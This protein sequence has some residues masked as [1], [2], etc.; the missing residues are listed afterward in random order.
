MSFEFA[1]AGRVLFGVGAL[2]QAGA[3][4]RSFGSRALLITGRSAQRAAA[5]EASLSASN[6]TCSRFALDG[7]PSVDEVMAATAVAR[8]Q[9]CEVIL[10]FGGGSAMDAAK[11]VAALLSNPGDPM[12]YLEVVGR[13]LPLV[14]VSIPCIAIPTTSGTGAEVTRN[15]VLA[16]PEH[17]VKVSLRGVG[18]LPRVA[19]VDP[20][21]TYDLPKS[22][23]ATTGLDALTQLIEPYVSQRA[24]PM[25][26]G[27]CL[28][29]IRRVS[30]S[31]ERA[32]ENP[33]DVAAR[34]DMSLGSLQGGLALANAGL[35][36]VH[37]FAGPIGGAFKA[38]HG[39]VCAALLATVMEAN[40]Q[41]LRLR[42]PNSNSLSRFRYISRL[43]LGKEDVTA[44][45]G[46]AW[47]RE[48]THRLDLPRLRDFGVRHE[49]FPSLI[50]KAS[51]S[52]SMKANPIVLTPV[53][54]K[55]IL[56]R[57]W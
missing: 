15:A 48:L 20:S 40:I 4:T 33:S 38:P 22:L 5:L 12:D 37:G 11:A 44:D 47:V 24:N 43:L 41:A 52:S 16:S 42:S 25:T 2:A 36:A 21:L 55:G 1:T 35:G 8:D 31:L 26:D 53:E 57:A 45:S 9:R 50:D 13:G 49:H 23:T 56:D 3:L 34:E 29:G 46:V 17:Q 18:M 6:V 39:A 51:R 30:R 10:G 32:C 19:L 28:D 54:L 7:E 14:N 27:F